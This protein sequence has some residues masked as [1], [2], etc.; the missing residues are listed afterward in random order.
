MVVLERGVLEDFDQLVE[1]GDF[2]QVVVD[3][4]H[5]LVVED[6]AVGDMVVEDK[7]VED[8]VVE[9]MAVEDMVVV[10]KVVVDMDKEAVHMAAEDRDM[11]VVRLVET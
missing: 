11:V 8:K 1:Q 4:E 5:M 3:L 7:V 6:M 2:E 9:D 10:G